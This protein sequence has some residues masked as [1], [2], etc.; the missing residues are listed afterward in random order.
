VSPTSIQTL[1]M[2]QAIEVTNPIPNAML[3]N[4]AQEA[5]SEDRG[6]R[7]QLRSRLSAPNRYPYELKSFVW[8]SARP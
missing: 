4:S 3:P 2:R 1:S 7:R 6:L 5:T 8:C